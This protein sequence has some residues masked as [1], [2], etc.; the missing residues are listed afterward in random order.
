MPEALVEPAVAIEQPLEKLPGVPGVPGSGGT[1]F[2]G[3]RVTR[4]RLRVL[5]AT[6]ARSD[7]TGPVFGMPAGGGG[8][9][10]CG[11]TIGMM[12]RYELP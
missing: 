11:F 5:A 4:L 3:V 10:A 9:T 2:A 8:A 6:R 1:S 12:L 7:P